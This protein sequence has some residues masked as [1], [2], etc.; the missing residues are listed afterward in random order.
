MLVNVPGSNQAFA[1]SEIQIKR[2]LFVSFK[3]TNL[4]DFQARG[5]VYLLVDN[6]REVISL[7][8]VSLASLLNR[9]LK[10]FA[11]TE[12]KPS[13]PAAAELAILTLE[14]MRMICMR[15]GTREALVWAHAFLLS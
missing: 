10:E 4:G 7:H 6:M 14:F 8:L 13:F 9:R 5:S 11:M 3:L 15:G 2:E 12:G 1:G